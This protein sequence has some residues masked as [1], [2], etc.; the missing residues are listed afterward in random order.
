VGGGVTLRLS[1]NTRSKYATMPTSNPRVN[2]TLTQEQYELLSRLGKLQK[3]SMAS[4]LAE[5]LA[6]VVPVLERVVVVG[7][8]AQRA[9]VQAKEGLRES[10]ERAEAA[11]LP[12]ITAAMD[13]FDLLL[14]DVTKSTERQGAAA[15][16]PQR[17]AQLPVG[18]GAPGK[19]KSPRSVTRGPGR[20]AKASKRR[21]STRKSVLRRGAGR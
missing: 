8:A 2:V 11:I 3:R 20:G 15:A 6:E 14:D 10:V 12:H 13:Q 1:R 19:R 9:Q 16:N 21:K 18:R 5:L 17:Q 7:E 4:V